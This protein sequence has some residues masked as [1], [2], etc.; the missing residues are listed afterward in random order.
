MRILRIKEKM[1]IK[2]NVNIQ[3]SQIKIVYASPK[4]AAFFAFLNRIGNKKYKE[5]LNYIK[6]VE[7][8]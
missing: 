2:N 6:T 7:S 8:G 1:T 5:N 4:S 3:F